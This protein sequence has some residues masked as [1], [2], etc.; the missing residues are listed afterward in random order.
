MMD[1]NVTKFYQNSVTLCLI[2]KPFEKLRKVFQFEFFFC[3]DFNVIIDD[4]DGNEAKGS[5]NVH[6]A[7]PH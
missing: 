5:H 7:G 6:C 4:A 1:E 2:A 3:R